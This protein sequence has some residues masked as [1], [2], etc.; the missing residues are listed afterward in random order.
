MPAYLVEQVVRMHPAS[1]QKAFPNR[2]VNNVYFDTSSFSTFHENQ[3]GIAYR[4]KYRVRW[5]GAFMQILQNPVLEVKVK[6][7][8]LGYKENFA[9]KNTSL[10]ELDQLKKIV[11]KQLQL[12]RTL[13]P[14]LLNAYQRSYWL[15]PNQKIR[16]TIDW[17]MKFHQLY[18]HPYFNRFHLKDPA[19]VV[20]LKY[21][22]DQEMAASRIMQDLPFR[23]TKNSKYAEGIGLLV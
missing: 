2:Q 13:S 21:D 1:F 6:D 8:L 3:S 23:L 7:N 17:D 19:V 14:V 11:N 10:Q 4:K 16:L 18:K 9:L 22:E 12:Y 20:E 15:T 5:Y